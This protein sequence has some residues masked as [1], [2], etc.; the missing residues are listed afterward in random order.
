MPLMTLNQW[1][2]TRRVDHVNVNIPLV[3]SFAP[4]YRAF[5]QPPNLKIFDQ[6]VTDVHAAPS[7]WDKA[8][9]LADLLIAMRPILN[10]PAHLFAH[11]HAVAPRNAFSTRTR[12]H[13][14]GNGRQTDRNH[15]RARTA[16]TG[17][18]LSGV[19]GR[20]GCGDRT[21]AEA[22]SSFISRTRTCIC[23]RWPC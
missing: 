12:I 8:T 18:S 22:I 15:A 2:Q 20:Q 3:G 11:R 7:S 1:V 5:D 19:V 9:K 4:R 16:R 13:M 6:S 17:S 10:P 21:C 23:R 14:A